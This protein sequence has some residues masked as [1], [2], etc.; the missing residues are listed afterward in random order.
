MAKAKTTNAE[1][2]TALEKRAKEIQEKA[3]QLKAQE[4]VRRDKE[5]RKQDTHRKVVL[6]G[7]IIDQ[8]KRGV[9]D[10]GAYEALIRQAHLTDR[11]RASIAYGQ[12][13]PRPTDRPAAPGVG[14]ELETGTSA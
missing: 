6:G 4:R 9:L 1:R 2:I 14:T 5:A 11:D 7:A 8:V 12:L 10:A 13:Y 3:K